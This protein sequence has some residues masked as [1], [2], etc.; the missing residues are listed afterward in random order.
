MM[1][2]PEVL[3][4]GAGVAGMTVAYELTRRGHLVTVVEFGPVPDPKTEFLTETWPDELPERGLGRGGAEYYPTAHFTSRRNAPYVIGTEVANS[5]LKRTRVVGGKTL[6]WTGHALRFSDVEF[7]A[8]STT[9]QGENWPITSAELTPFYKRAEQLMGVCGSFEGLSHQPDGEFLP[10]L[11]LRPG[12]R[13]LQK[14]LAAH[15]IPLIPAR[16]AILTRNFG[17]RPACHFA[18]RCYLGCRTGAK[19]DAYTGLTQAALQTG[20]LTLRPDSVVTEVLSNPAGQATGVRLINRK[21]RNVEVLNAKIV[22]LAASA[23]ETARILLN[24]KSPGKRYSLAN[25]SGLIGHYL[26][27]S[28]GVLVEGLLP[29]LKGTPVG[30]ITSTGE[31]GLIPRWV[32][33]SRTSQE[34]YSDG[35][36]FLV[37][38]GPGGFPTYAAQLPGFGKSLKQAIQ[39]WYP[40]AIRLYGIAPVTARRDN[41]VIVDPR[42]RDEWGIPTAKVVFSLSE[43][44]GLRWQAMTASAQEFLELA[45]AEYITVRQKGPETGG[46]L[47]AAGT[48]RMGNDP[49]TS[50]VTSFGQCHDVPNLFVADAA[51][52]VTSL[53][54]PTLTVM[55]LA[56]R[57]AEFIGK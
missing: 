43:E 51:T 33:L 54:Q 48:C 50:V 36:L 11:E 53:N 19:F 5:W 2:Y 3:I 28:I 47:H 20:K 29:Q 10:P 32:N 26:T 39:D 25:Q 12:E 44:D 55:A 46:G 35:F 41:R 21:T 31:H 16:K 1:S 7:Q 6:Y 9:G 49:K 56:L 34:S 8:V 13:I 52:F 4:V 30:D 38:S 37:E 45:G 15:H 23:I 42:H 24:S 18:G 22:V 14:A 57:Q 17:H 27:E 40:A